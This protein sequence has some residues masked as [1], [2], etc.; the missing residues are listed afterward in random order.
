MAMNEQERLNIDIFLE[1]QYEMIFHRDMISQEKKV[2]EV[3]K[4]K[5]V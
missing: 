2:F 3:R 5:S 4:E 1:D